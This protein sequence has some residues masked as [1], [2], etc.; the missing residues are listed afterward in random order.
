ML[1]TNWGKPNGNV[2]S[3]GSD[4]VGLESMWLKIVSQWLFMAMY[5]KILHLAY[6]ENQD[7]V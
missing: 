4:S 7:G 3:E 1:L 5:M 2:L 6:L